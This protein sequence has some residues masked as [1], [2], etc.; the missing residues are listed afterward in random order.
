[1]LLSCC[2]KGPD[3]WKGDVS[4][5]LEQTMLGV[6]SGEPDSVGK[7]WDCPQIVGDFIGQWAMCH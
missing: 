5:R 4:I 6:D 2:S 7:A 1:M 3:A